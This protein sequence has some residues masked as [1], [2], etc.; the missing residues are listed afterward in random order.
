[1]LFPTSKTPSE[2]EVEYRERRKEDRYQN[3]T[4]VS[5]AA[6]EYDATWAMALGLHNT[7]KMVTL[8]DSTGCEDLPGELVPL[9]RFD[10]MNNKMGCVLLKGFQQ[11]NF[12]GITV[13]L[14]GSIIIMLV[15]KYNIS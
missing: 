1:V 2:Y 11:V 15:P 4:E 8:N 9:E 5:I 6:S 3:L 13:R 10:Y 14:N 12:H 7:M